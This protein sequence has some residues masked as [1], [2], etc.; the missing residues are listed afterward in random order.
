[1]RRVVF[2]YSFGP[3]IVEVPEGVDR[4]WVQADAF[5]VPF[6]YWCKRLE[7]RRDVFLGYCSGSSQPATGLPPS[8]ED[9]LRRHVLDRQPDF[10][11][12]RSILEE[13]EEAR[14]RC[15]VGVF[16]FTK[17]MEPADPTPGI[18]RIAKGQRRIGVKR[19]TSASA[20]GKQN[21]L[22]IRNRNESS[23]G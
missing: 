5:Q 21:V 13:I 9:D 11:P 6:G 17:T 3:Y 22:I 4:S 10:K 15:T 14:L 23:P 16:L 20:R 2:D 8:M 7:Q 12:G 19:V 18:R 1:M